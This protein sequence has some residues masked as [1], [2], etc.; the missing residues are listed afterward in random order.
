MILWKDKIGKTFKQ[1]HQEQ[2]RKGLKTK[3]RHETEV[4]TNTTEIQISQDCCK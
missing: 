3:I 4:T 2:K 1:I